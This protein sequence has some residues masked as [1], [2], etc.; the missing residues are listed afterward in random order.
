MPAC[1]EGVFSIFSK[2]P[3]L[4]A[5]ELTALQ[6]KCPALFAEDLRPERQADGV[7]AVEG[8]SDVEGEVPEIAGIGVGELLSRA[9]QSIAWVAE[10]LKPR[11]AALP[12]AAAPPSTPSSAPPTPDGAPPPPT[13]KVERY[14]SIPQ[15]RGRIL[16]KGGQ[17]VERLQMQFG[18]RIDVPKLVQ[19][20][21]N[22]ESTMQVGIRGDEDCVDA[23]RAAILR[24]FHKETIGFASAG[25]FERGFGHSGLLHLERSWNAGR[26]DRSTH[27]VFKWQPRTCNLVIL[28]EFH[29][30]KRAK[31]SVL[32]KLPKTRTLEV[33]GWLLHDRDKRMELLRELAGIGSTTWDANGL[34]VTGKA[35][36]QYVCRFWRCLSWFKV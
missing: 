7:R 5:D 30:V 6:Q 9:N 13:R 10:V 31:D 2:F 14:V 25:D 21:Q 36:M 29:D 16:G 17:N 15:Q 12:H 33:P 27:V 32:A 24:L 19:D 4:T 3:G 8:D 1:N 26:P 22:L 11:R 35:G 28:G 34:T 20:D 23:C 18:V